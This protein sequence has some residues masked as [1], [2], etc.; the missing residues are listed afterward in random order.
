MGDDTDMD[1]IEFTTFTGYTPPREYQRMR[2][3]Y[4]VTMALAYLV[5]GVAVGLVIGGIL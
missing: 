1:D 5:I 3:A 2:Q 4:A